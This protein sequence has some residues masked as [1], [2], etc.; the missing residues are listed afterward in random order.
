[1]LYAICEFLADSRAQAAWGWQV[2]YSCLK[3]SYSITA[4]AAVFCANLVY[5]EE[6][7]LPPVSPES[8]ACQALHVCQQHHVSMTKESVHARKPS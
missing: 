3:Y 4:A 8:A 2:D 6:A 5:S 7:G 1:M